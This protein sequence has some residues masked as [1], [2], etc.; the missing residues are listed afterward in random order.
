MTIGICRD[1]WS[2]C[3]YIF[4]HRPQ[5]DSEASEKIEIEGAEIRIFRPSENF[6]RLIHQNKSDLA[7]RE[8]ETETERSPFADL[9]CC[10]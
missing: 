3:L 9:D 4:A 8:R 10:V 2:A 5:P 1:P 7:S 6:A